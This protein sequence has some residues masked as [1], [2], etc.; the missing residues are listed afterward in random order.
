LALAGQNPNAAPARKEPS[1]AMRSSIAC[2]SASTLRAAGPY[3]VDTG[4]QLVTQKQVLRF[5]PVARLE[6]VDDEHS[7]RVD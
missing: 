2:A 6:Q 4:T 3:C 7:E 5:Q 1:D